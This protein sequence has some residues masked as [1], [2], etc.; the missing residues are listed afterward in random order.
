MLPAIVDPSLGIREEFTL[1]TLTTR[2]G[3][4]LA[5][6]ISETTPQFVTILDPAGNKTKTARE[7]I[8]SL[9]ASAT[10]LMPEGLLNTL[11][12]EQTRDLFAWLMAK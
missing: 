3:Q 5:G 9:I 10:S 6:F 2:D 4:I 7:D 8:K 11:S 1:Q 12:P